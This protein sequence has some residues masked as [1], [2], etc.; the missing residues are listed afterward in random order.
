MDREAIPLVTDVKFLILLL[1]VLLLWLLGIELFKN[2]RLLLLLFKF[3]TF[4]NKASVVGGTAAAAVA[5]I[6]GKF[7]NGILLEFELA[8]VVVVVFE[9]VELFKKFIS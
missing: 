1:L 6:D 3:E 9:L 7:T 2:V 5:A 8:V 4:L